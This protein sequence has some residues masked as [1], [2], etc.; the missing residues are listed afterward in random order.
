MIDTGKVGTQILLL[1]SDCHSHLSEDAS[2]DQGGDISLPLIPFHDLLGK[3]LV[4]QM[5][6]Q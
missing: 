5:N 1:V 6:H 4:V 3:N 2:W